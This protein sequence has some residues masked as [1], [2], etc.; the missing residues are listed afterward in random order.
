[1][2]LIYVNW[3]VTQP[4]AIM[5]F[6]WDNLQVVKVPNLCFKIKPSHIEHFNMKSDEDLT[7]TYT[8]QGSP[9]LLN[10]PLKGEHCALS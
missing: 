1:M 7:K 4:E 5:N 3:E 10:M 6:C 9:C 8:W 2:L